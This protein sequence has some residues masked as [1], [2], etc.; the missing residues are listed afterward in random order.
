MI[1]LYAGNEK[2]MEV[3]RSLRVIA[4]H[5]KTHLPIFAARSSP[6]K[7]RKM[8]QN[9]SPS[10]LLST[11]PNGIRVSSSRVE[12]GGGWAEDRFKCGL[13]LVVRQLFSLLYT[14]I[15]FLLFRQSVSFY[16]GKKYNIARRG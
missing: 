10:P 16:A 9:S 5:A 3:G 1:V 12:C 14:Y 7:Q 8:L 2:R 4:T 13:H 6:G 11:C 15:V